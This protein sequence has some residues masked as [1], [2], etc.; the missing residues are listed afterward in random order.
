MSGISHTDL[1]ASLERAK[2]K[3]HKVTL[4]NQIIDD[5]TQM[6]Q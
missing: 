1:N 4:L 5:G 2:K 3:Y 6:T